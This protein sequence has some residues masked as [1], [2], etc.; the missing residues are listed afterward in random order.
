MKR[1]EYFEIRK[2]EKITKVKKLFDIFFKYNGNVEDIAKE[3]NVAKGYISTLLKDTI[4][5]ELISNGELEIETLKKIREQL[6][7]N[8]TAGRK[9]GGDNFV[10][11]HQ[12]EFNEEHRIIG[13]TRRPQ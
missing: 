5:N 1:E 3:L 13:H 8:Q 6:K 4:I 12:V 9:K 2:Q 7:T 11:N 10:K